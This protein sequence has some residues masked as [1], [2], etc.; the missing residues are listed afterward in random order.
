[1]SVIQIIIA[2]WLGGW[3]ISVGAYVWGAVKRARRAGTTWSPTQDLVS[4]TAL[5]LTWLPSLILYLYV[6]ARVRSE[7]P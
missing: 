4:I 7:S 2:I 6:R 1:M 5:L 3:L